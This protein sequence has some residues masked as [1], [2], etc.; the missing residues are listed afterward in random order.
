MKNIASKKKQKEEDKTNKKTK[1]KENPPSITDEPVIQ[2]PKFIPVEPKFKPVLDYDVPRQQPPQQYNHPPAPII[3]N[4]YYGTNDNNISN[5]K[6]T[7]KKKKVIVESSS[8]E[9]EEEYYEEHEIIQGGIQPTNP[10][11]KYKFV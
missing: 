8:S 11:L 7:T 6:K 5:K 4:Y 9:S 2:K 10:G 3:N 1:I